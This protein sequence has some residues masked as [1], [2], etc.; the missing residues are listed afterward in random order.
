MLSRAGSSL[1]PPMLRTSHGQ[2][3][4]SQGQR[5]KEWA[6]EN[7][8]PQ[9]FCAAGRLRQLGLCLDSAP[10]GWPQAAHISFQKLILS[11]VK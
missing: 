4:D 1:L 10:A 9:P 8:W 3:Y 11:F 6:L 5:N 7:R 2:S